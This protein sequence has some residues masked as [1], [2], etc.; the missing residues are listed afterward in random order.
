MR[1]LVGGGDGT[2]GWVLSVI[3][4]IFTAEQPSVAVLPLGTGNDLSRVLKWGSVYTDQSLVK[5]LYK[6]QESRCVKLDRWKIHTEPNNEIENEN[7]TSASTINSTQGEKLK[8]DVMSNYFSIGADA[9][10]CLEFH[11][12]RG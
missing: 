4:Q 11:E 3:E 7:E 5:I 10:V 2:V 12:R 1:I 8:N 6:V 9:H